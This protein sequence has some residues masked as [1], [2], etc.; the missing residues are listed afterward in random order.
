[1]CT[2]GSANFEPRRFDMPSLGFFDRS[3]GVG[4]DGGVEVYPSC[5]AT[6]PGDASEKRIESIPIL[7]VH[8]NKHLKHLDH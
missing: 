4:L 1:M 2:F 6:A 5:R 3:L 8:Q 7:V